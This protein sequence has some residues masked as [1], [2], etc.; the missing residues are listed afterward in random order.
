MPFPS[1]TPVPPYPRTNNPISGSNPH[2]P[3]Y[4]IHSFGHSMNQPHSTYNPSY[5]VP[6]QTIGHPSSY[7]AHIPPPVPGTFGNPYSTHPVGGTY[8]P[9]GHSYYPQQHVLAQPAAQP[10]IPGQTVI[11]VPGQQD[12]GRGFG[13]MVKEALV[14][15]TINAGVNRLINPHTHYIPDYNRPANPGTTASETHVTYNNHYFNNAPPGNTPSVP[16]S[17]NV[18]QGNVPVTYP[19]NYPNP[20]NNPVITPGV[21]IPTIVGNNGGVAYPASNGSSVNTMGTT[22]NMGGSP[23]GF[24]AGN[25]VND[26]KGPDQGTTVYSPQYKIS[27]N[28]LSMLTEELFA[29]QE[30]NISKYLTLYLQSKSENVTDAAKGP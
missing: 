21:S 17:P 25:T 27:D 30:V 11:M 4:P 3:P 23:N 13:Q 9:A 10:Y 2:S 19:A 28:D 26:Q 8:G 20:V 29:K 12:S 5:S 16:A 18:P 22:N 6:S 24:S 15:S 7:P 1:Y 14:F